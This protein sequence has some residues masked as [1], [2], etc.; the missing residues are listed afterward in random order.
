MK[1]S[2]SRRNTSS[3]RPATLFSA[4]AASGTLIAAVLGF[5]SVG[6]FDDLNKRRDSL[7]ADAITAGLQVEEAK[8]ASQ[9]A[10]LERRLQA[11]SASIE[12]GRNSSG[13]PLEGAALSAQDR[14]EISQ[15]SSDEKQVSARVAA[16]ESALMNDPVKALTVPLLRK[17]VDANQQ[18]ER[19]DIAEI[20]SE[21]DRLYTFAEWFMGLI[22]ASAVAILALAVPRIRLARDHGPGYGETDLKKTPSDAAQTSASG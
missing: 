9:Q 19:T 3:A 8:I 13:K 6:R 5:F 2:K 4:I 18:Q 15:T 10:V 21:V 14:A 7:Q 22:V 16:L 17:D 11:L 1:V 20:R 12:A